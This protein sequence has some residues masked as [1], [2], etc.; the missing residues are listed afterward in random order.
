MRLRRIDGQIVDVAIEK[1]SEQDQA[2]LESLA[3]SGETL[4][5][6]ANEPLPAESESALPNEAPAAETPD[7]QGKQVM[8]TEPSSSPPV[9]VPNADSEASGAPASVSAATAQGAAVPSP[10]QP[11]DAWYRRPGW[12]AATVGAIGLLVVLVAFAA[13][14][15][16]RNRAVTRTSNGGTNMRTAADSSGLS[17]CRYWMCSCGGVFEKEDLETKL[18]VLGD[19]AGA[20]I[21]GT[22]TCTNCGRTY[23]CG[24]IYD[25]KHDVPRQYWPQLEAQHGKRAC[26]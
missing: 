18:L 24:D 4:R 23:S 21:L 22:R 25:G 17:R 11:S 3:A 10:V 19:P 26:I 6:P 12:V 20:T 5:S 2:Y 8:E 9:A 13:R 15:R 7:T 16:W 1:L 14:R